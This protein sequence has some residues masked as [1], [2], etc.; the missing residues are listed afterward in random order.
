MP[1][2]AGKEPPVVLAAS[3]SPALQQRSMR[4][5][6]RRQH[7][8][9]NGE[10]DG[11]AGSWRLAPLQTHREYG[12]LARLA[13]YGHVPAHHARE[14]AGDGKAEPGSAELLRGGD[15]GLGEFFE[16][17]G[18]LLRRH[19]DASVGDG[20]LD[21]AAAIAHLACRKL[22]FT[23]FGELASIA[24]QVEQYLPQP[25]G[26]HGQCAEVLLGV[27]DEAVLVLLGKLSSGVDN[28]LDQR[29]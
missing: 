7:P 23:L 4:W 10:I 26:V 28:I 13:R 8:L 20:E 21:E 5:P 29:C 9:P 6:A 18:L 22:D 17:L 2:L 3:D 19:A 24:Q 12:A 1:R 27:N 15:I 16:Q 25:H 11:A 14:L